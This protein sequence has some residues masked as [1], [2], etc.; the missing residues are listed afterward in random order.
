MIESA[1]LPFLT[2]IRSIPLTRNTALKHAENGLMPRPIRIGS[3]L[4]YKSKDW[5]EWLESGCGPIENDWKPR[6]R[7]RQ[8]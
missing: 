2:A 5:Q 8:R 3:K 1:L 7:Q 4:F 6:S